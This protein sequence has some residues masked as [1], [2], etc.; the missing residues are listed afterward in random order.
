MYLRVLCRASFLATTLCVAACIAPESTQPTPRTAPEDGQ[1]GTARAKPPDEQEGVG[2]R[3]P[4]WRPADRDRAVKAQP[5][6]RPPDR[7]DPQFKAP[8]NREKEPRPDGPGGKLSAAEETVRTDLTAAA[9][10]KGEKAEFLEWGPHDPEGVVFGWP[11]VR[12]RYMV[13]A[14]VF[15]QAY[16]V[17]DG[18]ITDLRDVR[19]GKWWR[20]RVKGVEPFANTR[21]PLGPGMHYGPPATAE[22]NALLAQ[23]HVPTQQLLIFGPNLPENSSLLARYRLA[24]RAI[25]PG[26]PDRKGP[27]WGTT[28]GLNDVEARGAKSVVRVV[29]VSQDPPTDYLYFIGENGRVSPLRNPWGD[30]WTLEFAKR[31]P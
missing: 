20:E 29:N 12:V 2:K 23:G 13:G 7:D 1:K 22:E 5:D 26:D 19:G 10:K 18:K 11:A 6:G 30:N 9:R 8:P 3:N 25:P 15:D 4:W 28:L 21:A 14:M 16:R 24:V 31:L 17:D 27:L